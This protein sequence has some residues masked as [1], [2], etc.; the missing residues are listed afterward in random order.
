MQK[1]RYSDEEKA[2]ALAFVQ[3]CG[4]Q[5]KQASTATGIPWTTL[6]EWNE[7]RGVVPKVADIRSDR[8]KSLL[9]RLEARVDLLL[10]AVTP[11]R[12]ETASLVQVTTAL[13]T[14]IDKAAALRKSQA[15]TPEEL[16]R[17]MDEQRQQVAGIILRYVPDPEVRT[18]L[19]AELDGL[20]ARSEGGNR[21]GRA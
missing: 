14:L 4:G 20:A 1:R 15:V 16:A 3:A 12:I 19:S 5:Y 2:Q 9:E 10:G 21:S 8:E 11:D 17:Q 7:G 6:R 13:G 18:T